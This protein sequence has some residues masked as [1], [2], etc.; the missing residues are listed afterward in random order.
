MT[1]KTTGMAMLKDNTKS[2]IVNKIESIASKLLDIPTGVA[3]DSSVNE[4]FLNLPGYPKYLEGDSARLFYDVVRLFMRVE[5]FK[6]KISLRLL[7]RLLEKLLAEYLSTPHTKE[8]TALLIDKLESDAVAKVRTWHY[9]MAVE[10]V[11]LKTPDIEFGN[12]KLFQMD[13]ARLDSL[14]SQYFGIIEQMPVSDKVKQF[15]REQTQSEF[16]HAHDLRDKACFRLEIDGDENRAEELAI[17]EASPIIQIL[18]FLGHGY[19]WSTQKCLIGLGAAFTPQMR[20]FPRVSADLTTAGVSSQWTSDRRILEIDDSALARMN[21]LGLPEF[22]E[23]YERRDS[24]IS[25]IERALL[26]ALQFFYNGYT[27]LETTTE[28]MNYIMILECFLSPS[29]KEQLS[30]TIAE[31]AAILLKQDCEQRME[32][33]KYVKS[34]YT[35]RSSLVHGKRGNIDLISVRDAQY[36]SFKLIELVLKNRKLWK[37]QDDIAAHIDN[38]KFS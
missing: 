16:D 29:D 3:I 5:P 6:T 38:I 11:I 33:K 27:A 35:K 32:L 36:L 14:L 20:H 28:Y 37:Y 17:D 30:T 7:K 10:G 4:Y 8:Q 15:H 21:E 12:H 1:Y 31:G 19:H 26:R 34:L 25:D 24:D 9:Y 18:T 13:Q 23:I 22:I 2:E